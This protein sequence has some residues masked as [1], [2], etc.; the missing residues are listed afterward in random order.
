MLKKTP[1]KLEYSGVYINL[2]SVKVHEQFCFVGRYSVFRIFFPLKNLLFSC[3]NTDLCHCFLIVCFVYLVCIVLVGR[4]L[5]EAFYPNFTI[6]LKWS[7]HTHC[8]SRAIKGRGLRVKAALS[9][10]WYVLPR[11]AVLHFESR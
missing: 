11:L 4:A 8:V 5:L 6:T 3:G 2:Q 7:L 9:L 10:A 1:S